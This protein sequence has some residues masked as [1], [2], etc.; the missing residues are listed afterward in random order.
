MVCFMFA[1]RKL[2]GM[3]FLHFSLTNYYY[4]EFLDVGKEAAVEPE[5]DDMMEQKAVMAKVYGDDKNI[6]K[7]AATTRLGELP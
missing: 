4:R 7:V 2:H 3:L 1:C 5:D 6:A